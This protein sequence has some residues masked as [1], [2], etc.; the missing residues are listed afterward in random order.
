MN[1]YVLI[2]PR[3]RMATEVAITDYFA[4]PPDNAGSAP[5]CP[6]CGAYLRGMPWLPPYRVQLE[7]WS[8]TWADVAF[9]GDELL[10]SRTFVEAYERARLSGLDILGEVEI[11]RVKRFDGAKPPMPP[12]KYYAGQVRL[13]DALLDFEASQVGAMEPYSCERCRS[14]FI[15]R[16]ARVALEPGSWSGEDLFIARG[17]PGKYLTSQRYAEWRTEYG[18][19]GGLLIPADEYSED[20]YPWE[21][22][23][24]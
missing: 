18:I 13:S 19:N 15:K 20:A 6:A 5:Q 9:G 17:L 8:D 1:F 24:D 3:A 23:E 12:P 11:V 16:F 14:A 21:L 22:E 7:A 2:N 10:L 4:L